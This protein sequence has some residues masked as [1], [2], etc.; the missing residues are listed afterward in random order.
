MKS[1]W[2]GL[3]VLAVIFCTSETRS[4]EEDLSR[5]L[6]HVT[7]NIAQARVYIDSAYAGTTPLESYPIT[8]GKHAVCVLSEN[9]Q[10]WT[11][12]PACREIEVLPRQEIRLT[13]EVP[14]QLKISSEPYG[15][16]VVYHDSVLGRTPWIFSTVVG[17]GTIT[18]S[19][20]GYEN[21]TL[22][23][24][25]STSL[26]H[27][28]LISKQGNGTSFLEREESR[29]ITPIVVTASS[30]V[31]TGVAAAYLKIQ[32]DNLYNSYK[33]TGNASDLDR[34]HRLDT[35]A[36]FALV[37]SQFS[38]ALLTYFLLSR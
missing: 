6:L 2:C 10:R 37:A 21:L 23:F 22:V 30:A 14:R 31:L 12:T 33:N 11:T 7:S 20:D 36:G 13:V 38:I 27:G 18:L 29:S 4:Q 28:S 17:Q 24:D 19:K 9:D 8:A 1:L 26:L 3:I 5:G 32:A 25:P 34:V 15:A 16:Q 35:A